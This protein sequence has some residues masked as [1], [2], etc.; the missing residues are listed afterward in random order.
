MK[1]PKSVKLVSAIYFKDYKFLFTFTNQKQSIVDFKPIITH[2]TSLLGY[3]DISKFKDITINKETGD[4]HWGKDYDMCFHIEAYY[5]EKK[6]VPLF[7]LKQKGGRKKI[8]DKIVP[9]RLYIRNSVVEA[10]G[11]IEV[12]QKKCTDFANSI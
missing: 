12:M 4:I 9:L 1:P 7:P 8:E 6:I 2:G 11:G 10:N 3:L 5:N